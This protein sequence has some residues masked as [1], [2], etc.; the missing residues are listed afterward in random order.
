M[1][2][3][4]VL[5]SVLLAGTARA[6]PSPGGAPALHW[7]RLSG[8]ETCIDPIALARRVEAITG[9]LFVTPARADLSIAGEIAA[10]RDGFSVRITSSGARGEVLGERHLRSHGADCRSLDAAIAFVIA[11][12]LDPELALGAVPTDVL[13]RL[14]TEEDPGDA[15]L[16]ALAETPAAPAEPPSARAEFPVVSAPAAPPT[17]RRAERP[18][19]RAELAGGPVVLGRLLPDWSPGFALSL[20]ALLP[21]DVRAAVRVRYAR[22]LGASSLP[23]DRSASFSSTEAA[24]DVCP[25][26]FRR[27]TLAVHLCGSVL[28]AH[29]AAQGRGFGKNRRAGLWE[30]GLEASLRPSYG[31][32]ALAVFVD[33]G[34]R[35]RLGDRRFLMRSADGVA[36]VAHTPPRLAVVAQLGFSYVFGK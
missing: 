23:R 1:R 6:E 11:V 21:A 10:A 29:L 16:Q 13:G 27:D 17:P 2:A 35:W 9:P 31:I 25:R 7:V 19:A 14:A 34:V 20:G 36:S 22:G 28:A 3:R 12:T 4:L 33:A 32:G 5:A 15:L 18:R 30:A 26:L 24:L 8:A